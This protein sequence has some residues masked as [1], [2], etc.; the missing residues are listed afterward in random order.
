MINKFA[1]KRFV[2]K[3]LIKERQA[4]LIYNKTINMYNRIVIIMKLY[5][6]YRL[7]VSVYALYIN[8]HNLNAENL[9]ICKFIFYG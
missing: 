9:G 7:V 6:K 1:M 2:S 3:R 4:K 5:R 8:L